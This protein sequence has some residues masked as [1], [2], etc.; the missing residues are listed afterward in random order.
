MVTKNFF[1]LLCPSFQIISPKGLSVIVINRGVSDIL[2]FVAALLVAFGHYSS[3]ALDYTSNIILRLLTMTGGYTGVAIF[4]FLS[5]YGL[6]MSERNR[7]LGFVAFCRRRLS[8]VYVPVVIVSAVWAIVIWPDG[9]GLSH[10]PSY[11]YTTFIGFADGILWYVRVI[12]VMYLLFYGYTLLRNCEKWRMP[13][14]IIGTTFAYTFV[15]YRHASYCAIS[16]PLFTLGIVLAEFNDLCAKVFRCW[17]WLLLWLV[18]ITLVMLILYCLYGNLYAHSLLNYYVVTAIVTLCAFVSINV[19]P[20]AW[21]GGMSY[22]IYLTHYKVMKFLMPVYGYIPLHHFVVGAVI[23][24]TASYALR[25][26]VVQTI[27][28]FRTIIIDIFF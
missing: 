28:K 8:K 27:C 17:A 15:Y 25:G 26:V 20:P 4:F 22:D 21:L 10:I 7:H 16:V 23:A 24:A 9:E 13:A 12:A 14:L 2:K 6:M 19:T 11:L 18:A 1:E 5:G 3:H